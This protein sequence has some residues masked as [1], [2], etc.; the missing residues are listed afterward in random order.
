MLLASTSTLVLMSLLTLFI[1]APINICITRHTFAR[2]TS[3]D[4]INEDVGLITSISQEQ[5]ISR[6]TFHVVDTGV[7][8]GR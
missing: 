5:Y 2:F 4:G 7:N 6:A 1:L 8:I 3:N